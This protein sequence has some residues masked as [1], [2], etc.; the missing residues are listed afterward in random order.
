[1]LIAN[2]QKEKNNACL[3]LQKERDNYKLQLQKCAK[4]QEQ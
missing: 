4:A 2:L 3:A 1:M